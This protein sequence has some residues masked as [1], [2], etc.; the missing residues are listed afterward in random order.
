MSAAPASALAIVAGTLAAAFAL[1][2][3]LSPSEWAARHLVLADGAR[4]GEIMDMS[5][6]PYLREPLDFFS[7]ECPDNRC[8]IRKSKQTGFTT[9]AIA[10]IGYSIDVEPCHIFLIEPTLQ[11]LREFIAEKLQPTIEGTEPLRRKVAKQVARSGDGSTTLIKRF[12]AYSL[13]MGTATSTANLRGKTRKKVIRD[14]AS[15]YPEDLDGQGSP[16]DMIAGAYESFLSEGSWKNLAISTPVVK[17]ACQIDRE[18]EAGD[19]RYWH[20]PCP[21]CGGEFVF[22]FDL[23]H[24][25]FNP[26]YP[27]RAHYVTPCCDTVIEHEQKLEL[28]RRGRWIAT[29]PGPGRPRSYH[30]DSL[31]SPFVP[32]DEIAE[33][34]LRAGDNPAAL[35]AFY[36]L[37]LGLPYEPRGDAPDHVALMER[38]EDYAEG[39]VP[40]AGLILVGGADVQHDG[41]Y[42]EIVAFARDRQSWCVLAQYL[43]GDT[44]DPDGGA[45]AKLAALY[46]QRFPDAFGGVREIDA[47]AVDAGDGGRAN[48]VYAFCRGRPRLYAIK[49]MPGWT[50]PAIGTPSKVD[51]NLAGR[52]IRRGVNLWPVGTWALKATLYADLRKGGRRAGAA[53]D[54]PG[55]CHHHLNLDERYFRQLTSEYLDE[56][57]I[58]G[59]RV[60]IWRQT[61]PNHYLDARIYAMAMAEMLGLTR[62]SEEQWNE[63]AAHRGA[64]PALTAPDLFR[65]L[66]VP[67]AAAAAHAA[68]PAPSAGWRARVQGWWER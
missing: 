36:N 32:W 62:M 56:A 38:R 39:R 46:Q 2:A 29:A 22:R 52:R 45:F 24:F 40:A 42:V 59:R 58:R 51:I 15:E 64:P 13:L 11:S 14:E 31:S 26:S 49:G 66:P 48:Q 57:T 9:M 65:P 18:F 21:G 27:Y 10:A 55:Y 25:R 63:L 60:R 30:F 44:T 41:I 35:K 20:V 8:A 6:T 23:K 12:G 34:Y 54:P 1:P 67:A 53:A 47:L 3:H 33:R 37:T 17:G 68:A 4:A 43:E 7:D 19:Q 50:H 61:R 5:L 16:H 28:V